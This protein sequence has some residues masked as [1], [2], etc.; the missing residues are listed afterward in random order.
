MSAE[1]LYVQSAKLNG[2]PLLRAEL[3]Q[4]ELIDGGKLVLVMGAAPSDWA[5]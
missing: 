3:T 1:N 5:H 2:A 4:S